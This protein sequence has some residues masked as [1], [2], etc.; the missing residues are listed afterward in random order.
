MIIEIKVIDDDNIKTSI[1]FEA[2]LEHIDGLET[3]FRNFSKFLMKVGAE[4]PEELEKFIL[5]E[6]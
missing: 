4:F 1:E 3:T 2:D 5:N 6:I